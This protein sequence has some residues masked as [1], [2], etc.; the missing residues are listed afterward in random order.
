MTLCNGVF[1][2]RNGIHITCYCEG[3]VVG[4]V[5]TLIDKVRNS[6]EETYRNILSRIFDG[7]AV[8]GPDR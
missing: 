1:Y 2:K 7:D 8:L 4:R 3:C 5:R 6:N